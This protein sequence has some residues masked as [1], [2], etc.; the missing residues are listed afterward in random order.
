MTLKRALYNISKE[1]CTTYG[2]YPLQYMERAHAICEKSL[3]HEKSPL[4]YI[5]RALR[6][7]TYGNYPMQFMIETLCNI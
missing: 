5:E 6:C 3:I 7:T 4:R 1:S 2:K